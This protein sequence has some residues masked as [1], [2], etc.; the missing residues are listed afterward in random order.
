ALR[1]GPR[2]E[3]PL[4]RDA[5]ALGA[6]RA[7]RLWHPV[8]GETDY[9]GLATALAAA[10]THLEGQLLL[11]GDHG[12]GAVGPAVAE[13]LGWPHLCGVIGAALEEDTEGGGARLVVERRTSW[14]RQRLRGPAEAVL[15]VAA[16]P[17]AGDKRGDMA[18][19]SIEVLDLQDVGLDRLDLGHRR[20]LLPQA[21]AA[22]VLR[23][24]PRCFPSADALLARLHKD[25]VLPR[26]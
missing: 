23:P 20:H 3:E 16:G 1:A 10:A 2:E 22:P 21:G 17:A 15:C 5:L 19:A 14:G 24:T 9:L 11:A 8:L 4:L 25:G 6:K 7:V 18:G 13:R 12:G 26:G